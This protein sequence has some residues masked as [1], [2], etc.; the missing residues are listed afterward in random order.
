MDFWLVQMTQR[1]FLEMQKSL[2]KHLKKIQRVGYSQMLKKISQLQV[3]SV[4]KLHQII[5]LL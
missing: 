1:L 4:Q 5:K 2:D 3:Y